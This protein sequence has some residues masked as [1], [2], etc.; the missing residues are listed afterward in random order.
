MI[1]ELSVENLAIIDKTQIALGPG[2]TVLTGETGA[3]KTL[4]VDAIELALGERADS[5]QVR[6]GAK[7]ASVSL[8]FDVSGF[9]ETQRRCIELGIH[10]E[11]GQVFISREIVVEGRSQCRV[12]GKLTPVSVLKQL[13]QLLVDLHG[14]HDH[15]ALLFPDRH[16]GY[17]DQW[18]GLDAE[19][20]L[21]RVS[22]AYQNHRKT[23]ADLELVRT[24]IRERE[25]RLDLLNYQIAEI[26]AVDPKI[27]ETELL[28]AHLNKLQHVEK[29]TAATFA[30][31][32]ALS[33][34]EGSAAEQIGNAAKE[35]EAAA[36]FD[37]HLEGPAKSLHDLQYQLEDVVRA[38][39]G[40]SSSLEF[41][42]G[43][44]EEVS[45][46]LDNLWKL[47]RKYGDTEE[48]VLAFQNSAREQRA[49]VEDATASETLLARQEE[50]FRA[51][52]LSAANELSALRENKAVEFSSLIET[53]LHELALESARFSVSMR[54]KEPD[55]TGLDD[56][57]FLFTANPGEPLRPLAKIASGGEVSRL[58]LAIKT[59]LAG[60]AGVPCL[61][62]DEID[63]GM[64][65]RI[66][67]T[68]GRKLAEL[69]MEYQVIVISH[70]PQ[71]AARGEVHF[72]IDKA[73]A[74]GRNVTRIRKLDAKER[75][76]EIARMLGGEKVSEA[77]L[78]NARELLAQK[79]VEV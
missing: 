8:V 75:E 59:V 41:D 34:Q 39:A 23:K 10:P 57:E 42:A 63:T 2:Y 16:L 61:I 67:A 54:E 52:L 51:E 5:D 66:A 32:Q 65:G 15:Q 1:T 48:E 64:S 35:L 30:A 11:D 53:Q 14:Q 78:G 38:L 22:A 74:D 69:A 58:M 29:L 62:F 21:N 3:G 25:Q 79:V 7:S 26:E 68:I 12:N 46:R 31:L 6:K 43:S 50:Q 27:G 19:L 73:K 71:V 33:E 40:Y 18:I 24:G 77:A 4:L 55:Q 17:L 56:A 76:N 47:K 13:G 20:L 72:K 44:L 49:I 70:L 45:G 9:F 60:R 37:S 28:T 36:R